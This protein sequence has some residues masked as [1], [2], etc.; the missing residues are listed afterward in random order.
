MNPVIINCTEPDWGNVLRSKRRDGLTRRQ[1]A[2]KQKPLPEWIKTD[3]GRVLM[4]PRVFIGSSREA[5]PIADALQKKLEDAAEVTVW[6]QEIFR[7]SEYVLESLL[8]RLE[9]TDFGVFVFAPDDLVQIR[10]QQQQ[11]VRDNVVFELGLFIGRLGRACT[12]I[13]RPKGE[14]LRMPSDLLG[15]NDLTFDAKRQDKNLVAA[16]SP[17]S[18]D[19]KGLLER[20]SARFKRFPSELSM[21]ILERHDLLSEGQRKI[22][23]AIESREECSKEELAKVFVQMPASELYYRLEQLRLLMFLSAEDDST[24]NTPKTNYALCDS[25]RDAL[26]ASRSKIRM[27][28][29]AVPSK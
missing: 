5:L 10:G 15:L 28:S 9:E 6:D 8:E 20:A 1:A 23:A 2:L 18:T 29:R 12:A 3:K 13:V 25:Y 24:G 27:G 19:I 7:A 4:R 14:M 16:L 11:T 26:Q 21:S 22:L 17:V